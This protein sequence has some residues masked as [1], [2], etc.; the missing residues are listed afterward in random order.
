M[1]YRLLLP[2]AVRYSSSGF[3]LPGNGD[4]AH[5][6]Q[7]FAD[8][9][10]SGCN[11]VSG[12]DFVPPTVSPIHLADGGPHRL[13]AVH[14]HH[15]QLRARLPHVAFATTVPDPVPSRTKVG[16]AFSLP[17]ERSSPISP[18]SRLLYP[19]HDKPPCF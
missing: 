19:S 1:R 5:G 14:L 7:A 3:H 10:C 11:T 18:A 6:K 8:L 4:A 16:Q 12:A 17:G 9:G 15:P 2:I 13:P